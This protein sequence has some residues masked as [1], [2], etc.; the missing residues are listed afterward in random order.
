MVQLLTCHCSDPETVALL[1]TNL[2]TP[3]HV[4]TLGPNLIQDK[5]SYDAVLYHAS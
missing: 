2:T 1:S 5:L 4:L 3:V